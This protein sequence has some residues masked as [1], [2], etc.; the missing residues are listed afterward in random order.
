MPVARFHMQGSEHEISRDMTVVFRAACE[1]LGLDDPADPI[2]EV[3]AL[4]IIEL[5]HGGENEPLR[6]CKGV[7]KHFVSR[8]REAARRKRDTRGEQSKLQH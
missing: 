7:M 8:R 2:T 4:K 5:A 3:V 1:M 6:L